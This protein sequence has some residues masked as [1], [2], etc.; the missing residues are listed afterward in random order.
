MDRELGDN[1]VLGTSYPNGERYQVCVMDRG[2]PK[3]TRQHL[4]APSSKGVAVTAVETHVSFAVAGL[5]PV[6][7]SAAAG[8]SSAWLR[9]PS[10]KLRG[11]AVL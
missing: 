8:L 5:D 4:A 11:T 6:S 3:D 10:E 2:A 7:S 1:V 9:R